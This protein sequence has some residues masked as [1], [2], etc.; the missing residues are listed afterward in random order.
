MSSQSQKTARLD[1]LDL[2]DNPGGLLDQAIRVSD[3]FLS[4]GMIVAHAGGSSP[5]S[6]K[7]ATYVDTQPD[8]PIVVLVNNGSASASEIVAGALKNNNRALVLG[9]RT[10]G[11]GTVQI[12]YP[13]ISRFSPERTAFKS[14]DRRSIPHPRKHLHQRYPAAPIFLSPVH[15]HRDSSAAF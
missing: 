1:P 7:Y 6:E 8:Y 3:A 9:Q 11:K 2:R 5:P 14:S 12:L 15:I 4:K 13:I 10:Y